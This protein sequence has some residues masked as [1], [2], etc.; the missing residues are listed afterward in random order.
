MAS[1]CCKCERESPPKMELES[2]NE[3]EKEKENQ[4]D[5][6][7]SFSKTSQPYR[8]PPSTSSSSSSSTSSLPLSHPLTHTSSLPQTTAAVPL[9]G[10]P[11]GLITPSPSSSSSSQSL[12]PLSTLSPSNHSSHDDI[13]SRQSHRAGHHLKAHPSS[14]SQVALSDVGDPSEGSCEASRPSNIWESLYQNIQNPLRS[15]KEKERER[16]RRGRERQS[17]MGREMGSEAGVLGKVFLHLHSRLLVFFPIP[18]PF[19]IFIFV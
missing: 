2:K 14:R 18:F 3:N 19:C 4:K 13:A 15:H 12:S 7:L 9:I 1:D 6:R 16:E 10:P 5:R 8:S 11:P 17:L